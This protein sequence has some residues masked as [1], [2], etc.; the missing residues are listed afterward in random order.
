MRHP[1]HHQG[2]ETVIVKYSLQRRSMRGA[3][4][5][6]PKRSHYVVHDRQVVLV[7][8]GLADQI[9]EL[10]RRNELRSAN[11]ADY[12]RYRCHQVVVEQHG[13]VDEWTGFG[14]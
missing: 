5:R 8:Q 12:F 3:P 10:G 6:P 11:L 2:M 1:V 14:L 9:R 7:G 13:R 4:K